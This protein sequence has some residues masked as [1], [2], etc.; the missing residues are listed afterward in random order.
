M[1]KIYLVQVHTTDPEEKQ[2]VQVLDEK[3]Q[4]KIVFY[5]YRYSAEVRTQ[6]RRVRGKYLRRFWGVSF[7]FYGLKLAAED[8]RPTIEEA[9]KNMIKD[10]SAIAP[11]IH[12]SVT[13][14]PITLDSNN[15]DLANLVKKEIKKSIYTEMTRRLEPYVN[16]AMSGKSKT[17]ILRA[18]E[19]MRKKNIL[20]SE[21]VDNILSGLKIKVEGDT[22]V[23]AVLNEVETQLELMKN[24][25]SLVEL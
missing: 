24:D 7:N 12:G 5:R 25:I 13:L 21:E 11:D 17:A 3:D 19:V 23:Q 22:E 15:S 1:T 9:A 14:T 16:A 4:E 8:T 10:L 20:G 2:D 6:I 18:L